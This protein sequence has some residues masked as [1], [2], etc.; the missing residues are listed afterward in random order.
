MM[1]AHAASGTRVIRK[2]WKGLMKFWATRR[3]AERARCEDHPV[4]EGPRPARDAH[5]EAEQGQAGG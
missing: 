5:A 2:L 4:D 3:H 1:P